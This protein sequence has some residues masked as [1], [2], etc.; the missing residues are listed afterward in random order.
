MVA[1]G[2]ALLFA[3]F[4]RQMLLE[5]R[6]RL[7]AGQLMLKASHDRALTVLLTSQWDG[8]IITEGVNP[9]TARMDQAGRAFATAAGYVAHAICETACTDKPK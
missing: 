2:D 5:L 3:W 4:K 6:P 8:G 1:P 9:S 7:S